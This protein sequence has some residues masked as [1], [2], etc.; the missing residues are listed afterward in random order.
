MN[1][2][3]KK[4]R[5]LAALNND[6][7]DRI[8]HSIWFHFPHK[9]QDPLS[10][11]LAQVEH[12]TKF[13][14]DFIKLMPFGLYSAQDYGPKVKIFGTETESPIIE[15]FIIK[16][17]K[18]WE[19]I[20]VYNGTY[21]TLG[22]QVQLAKHVYRLL[23]GMRDDAPF[24]QTIFSPLTTAYKFAGER[25]IKDL[26]ENPILVHKALQNVTETTINFIKENIKAGVSGFFFATQCATPDI[27]TEE[28]YDEFGTKYD[29]QLFDAFK[30]DT[31]FNI[32]HIHGENTMF[33]KLINY[34][35]NCINWHDRTVGPSIEETR[36]LTDK[37]LLCGIEEYDFLYRSNPEE[38]DKH[39]KEAIDIAGKK[40]IMIGPGCVVDPPNSPD[41][42]YY[43]ARIAVQ[44]YGSNR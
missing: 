30:N 11:A 15:D 16:D 31:F 8:P 36:K 37:C 9:D 42:N 3:T 7:V 19:D 14:Q 40:G 6:E 32:I 12:M 24:V 35:G 23:K 41:V 10:L 25:V 2:M 43:A 4:E 26:R 20:E 28:E 39:I 44:K 1:L 27:M 18:E 5:V 29:L 17:I 34:P 22:K 38:I 21:G 13:D 33:E